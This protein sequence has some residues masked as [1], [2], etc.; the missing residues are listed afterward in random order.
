MRKHHS[1]TAIIEKDLK[2]NLFVAY[3]PG[4]PG[5]HTQAKTM[6]ELQT[7]LQEVLTLVLGDKKHEKTESQFVGT[8]TVSV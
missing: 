5:A 4:L 2:T 1:F 3:I 6:E 7:N 8:Q